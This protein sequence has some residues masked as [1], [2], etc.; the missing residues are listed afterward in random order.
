MMAIVS[1]S[2]DFTEVVRLPEANVEG[3]A[4]LV[5]SLSKRRKIWR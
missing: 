3:G 4:S 2:I 1:Q 5:E